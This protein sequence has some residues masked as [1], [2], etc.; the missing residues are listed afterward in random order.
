MTNKGENK[1]AD[2]VGLVVA[3]Y[4]ITALLTVVYIAH[5]Y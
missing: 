1:Y 4:T 5:K 2:L 3:L